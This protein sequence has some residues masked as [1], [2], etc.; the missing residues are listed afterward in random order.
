MQIN[1]VATVFTSRGMQ[2]MEGGWPKEV[3]PTEAE[4]VIRYRRKARCDVH[5]TWGLPNTDVRVD[6]ATTPSSAPVHGALPLS[7]EMSS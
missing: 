1:T 5:S 2:H 6:C 7:V 3:D 4:H